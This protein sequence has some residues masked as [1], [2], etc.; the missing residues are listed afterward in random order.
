[1]AVITPGGKRAEGFRLGRGGRSGSGS[2][3]LVRCA[4]WDRR[5]IFFSLVCG[6]YRPLL[7][8]RCSRPPVQDSPLVAHARKEAVDGEAV[9]RPTLRGPRVGLL[10]SIPVRHA[11]AGDGLY[12]LVRAHVK[13]Y[14]TVIVRSLVRAQRY[15]S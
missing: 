2:V 10:V 6:H 11:L 12:E 3:L 9:S 13:R 1:M 14:A 5:G 8:W 4:L 15:R 7:S